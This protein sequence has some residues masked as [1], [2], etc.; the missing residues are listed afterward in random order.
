MQNKTLIKGNLETIILKLLQDNGEMYGYQISKR[1]KKMTDAEI[2]ITEGALYPALHKLE[3]AGNLDI[4]Q[5][6]IDGRARKYY[7]I[8][9]EGK[10]E[11]ARKIA[12][13]ETF[14]SS[15]YM[16]LNPVAKCK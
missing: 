6:T 12:E 7:C 13:F 14:V 16:I 1:V 9:K 11:V 2:Q 5:Q 10:K 15:M 4:R 3:A 8:S